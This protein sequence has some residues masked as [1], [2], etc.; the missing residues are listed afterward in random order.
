MAPRLT[1][2]KFYKLFLGYLFH[3]TTRI[4]QLTT[5]QKSWGGETPIP[6][7]MDAPAWGSLVSYSERLD[8]SAFNLSSGYNS[9]SPFLTR[10]LFSAWVALSKNKIEF[11]RESKDVSTFH[12]QFAS[13]HHCKPRGQTRLLPPKGPPP[14]RASSRGELRIGFSRLV[15]ASSVFFFFHAQ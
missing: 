5:F 15:A 4:S 13:W 14:R 1:K 11:R 12:Q 10:S 3:K 2:S 6:P 7:Q 8:T 9:K